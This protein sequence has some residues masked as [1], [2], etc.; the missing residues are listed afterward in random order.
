VLVGIICYAAVTWYFGGD[1]PGT[2]KAAAQEK[3]KGTDRIVTVPRKGESN[4]TPLYFGVSQCSFEGCHGDKEPRK[5]NPEKPIVCKCNEVTI[6][7]KSDKHSVA[8]HVIDTRDPKNPK[9]TRARQM[10]KILARGDAS[11]KVHEDPRCLACH[12]MVIDPKVEQHESFQKNGLSD[13]VNCVVCHGAYSE[14]VGEHTPQNVGWAKFRKLS[15]SEKQRLKGMIDLWDGSNRARLCSSCHIGNQ[16]QGKFVTHE[17]YAAGHPPLPS[18][19][20]AAFSNEM[21]RHWDYRQEKPDVV[22]KLQGISKAEAD[23]TK[24]VLVGAAIS[25]AESMKLLADQARKASAEKDV[26][27]LSNFDCYAC[28]HDLKAPSWR[29]KRGY[30]G[31][32]GRLPMRPWSTEL[33]QLAILHVADGNEATAKKL[34]GELDST[35]KNLNDAFSLRQYGDTIAIE[36]VA[37]KLAKWATTLAARVDKKGCTKQDAEKIYRLIP[38]LY[39]SAGGPGKT[40]MLLDYDSARQVGWAFEV[41]Y[42]E[43]TREG[44]GSQAVRGTIKKLDKELKLRLPKAPDIIETEL[45]ATLDT[46]NNYDPYRFRKLLTELGSELG[47]KR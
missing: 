37:S 8:F 3:E 40:R 31:K 1:V 47:K 13:G 2:R 45:K 6:W 41:I 19:E 10:E 14:W 25:L 16:E 26:L 4:A 44:G 20:P 5:F 34:Q 35:L 18:F 29:Q 32:P 39:T 33:V 24:L 9:A 43:S 38:R 46:V 15:R 42:D 36:K 23:Q 17:M 12:A 22:L 28:H 7:Q 21:P 30:P 27:D 11:Y